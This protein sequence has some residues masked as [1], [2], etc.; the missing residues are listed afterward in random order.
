M[1]PSAS[2]WDDASEVEQ[3]GIWADEPGPFAASSAGAGRTGS[4]SARG[5]GGR[6]RALGENITSTDRT[7]GPHGFLVADVPNRI[8]ALAIDIIVFA[9]SGF[10]W[11]WFLGGLVTQPGAIGAAGGE[12]DAVAFL[13][14]L[15]LQLAISFV[16]LAGTWVLLGWTPGMRLLGLRLGDEID[17][18]PISWRPALVRW[19][20]LG[21]PALLASVA[22][23]VTHGVGIILSALGLAWLAL[24]LYTMAQSPGRQGFHDRLAHTIVVRARR[25]HR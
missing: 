5:P 23:Y 22:I 4:R 2:P 13:V 17:G 18:G 3:A 6:T 20:I 24:L 8:M 10:A 7:P 9:L 16:Y 11:V 15:G 1:T 21:I 19:T 12:L 25:R 14:V